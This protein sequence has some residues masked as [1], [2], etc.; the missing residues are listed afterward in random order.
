M[1]AD[2]EVPDSPAAGRGHRAAAGE[3]DLLRTQLLDAAERLLSQKGSLDAVSLRQVARDVGV[4]ATSVYLHFR[5]KQDLFIGVCSRRFEDL[6]AA[7]R[8]ARAGFDSPVDQLRASGA[9]YVRF[10]LER[11]VEY[12]VLFGAMPMDV[13]LDRVPE[14]EL[15]GLQTLAE[16]AGLVQEGMD[17]GVFRT[18]D[19]FTTAVSLWS[20]CHGLVGALDH[21]H[22]K[23]GIT[24]AD[25]IETTLD[26]VL[27]GLRPR[28]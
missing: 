11:P 23:P 21:G 17:A 6:A 8:E 20:V 7:L 1:S 18:G 12:K 19:A 24:A 2:T 14:E 28:G 26:M 4:S 25:V 15:V 16:L 5:D 3:G 13:I 27:E 22:G 9:A 10:G